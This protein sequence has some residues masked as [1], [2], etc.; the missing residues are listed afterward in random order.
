[1]RKKDILEYRE[2]RWSMW[3]TRA[4]VLLCIASD[5]ICCFQYSSLLFNEFA[6]VS[7]LVSMVTAVGLDASLAYAATMLNGVRPRSCTARRRRALG[8][9]GMFAVFL[10]SYGCLVLMAWSAEAQAEADLLR[11]GTVARL[12]LPVATSILSFVMGWNLD[13][14]GA[15][16]QKIRQTC[17][18]LEREILAVRA[19]CERTE[20]VLA[21][22]EPSSYDES[23]FRLAALRVKAAM[24]EAQS[25]IR[26]QLAEELGYN[27]AVDA[28]LR[29]DGLFLE[30]GIGELDQFELNIAPKRP[31][32]DRRPG[33]ER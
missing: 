12:I 20:A 16:L 3:L 23:M 10:L 13:P 28:I 9:G 22:F 27:E 18:E 7:W 30:R 29:R 4:I 14:A 25:Q 11:D 17:A 1:M 5:F 8:V 15:R 19:D 24:A 32:E 26:L 21:R 2:R 31:H 33:G 6:W